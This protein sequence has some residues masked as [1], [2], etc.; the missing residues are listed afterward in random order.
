MSRSGYSEDGDDNWAMIRWRGMVAS[1]SRGKRGQKL[2]REMLAALDAMPKKRLIANDL[3]IQATGEVCALGALA[4]F[5]GIDVSSV[6][7]DDYD[8]VSGIFDV[9]PCLAQEV[10]FAND[11]WFYGLTPEARWEKMRAWVVSQIIEP[12]P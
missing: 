8:T 10:V 1:A 3:K 2:F 4:D 7:P 9:A 6:D 5:R 11:E 12:S